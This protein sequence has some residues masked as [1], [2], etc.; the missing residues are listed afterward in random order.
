M[1]PLRSSSMGMACHL[2]K[3]S[4]NALASLQQACFDISKILT[5]FGVRLS[6]ATSSVLSQLSQSTS[7]EQVASRR[8]SA[9][10]TARLEFFAMHEPMA[11]LGRM[12]SEEVPEARDAIYRLRQGL[13]EQVLRQF[14]PE[15]STMRQPHRR[16]CETTICSLT[17][18]DSWSLMRADGLDRDEILRTWRFAIT[19]LLGNS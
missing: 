1:P 4:L 15:F 13:N 2:P 10:C 9:L 17:S 18:F 19:R 7:S 14:E 6:P 16:Y 5:T 8:V 11:T 3:R 12:R